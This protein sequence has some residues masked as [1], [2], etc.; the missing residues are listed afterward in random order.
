MLLFVNGTIMWAM[1]RIRLLIGF[2]VV[3]VK[4]GVGDFDFI[5]QENPMVS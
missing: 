4:N 3:D 2:I 1:D 5:L